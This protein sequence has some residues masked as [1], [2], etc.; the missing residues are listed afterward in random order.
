MLPTFAT[1]SDAAAR[2]PYPDQD[3]QS[4]LAF[5]RFMAKR[6][7]LS[8]MTSRF[9]YSIAVAL[10]LVGGTLAPGAQQYSIGN[11]TN[12]EQAYLEMIN[13][14][15]AHPAAEGVLLA[16]TTDPRVLQAYAA[17]GVNL[18]LMRAQMAAIAPLPPLAMNAQLNS[19]ARAHSQD[20]LA[21]H[22]QG[23]VG[24]DGRNLTARII[25]SGYTAGAS[26][27]FGENVF[28]HAVSPFHGHACLEVDWG[29]SAGS[30]GM[31][32]PP[33]HRNNIHS[34]TFREIGIGV[35]LGSNQGVGPQLVTQ[36]FGCPEHRVSF[37]HRCGLSG[38]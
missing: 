37:H 15:R 4:I 16:T 2:R 28:S 18:V 10:F 17:F 19:V 14:A 9:P 3:K 20:M 5:F 31:Q 7:A 1:H 36:D 29:G 6:D 30:G 23:H 34:S 32:V 22:F 12:E 33:G 38:Q 35:A 26:A 27:S 11:P 25:A 13:R 8:T 21:N 24:S